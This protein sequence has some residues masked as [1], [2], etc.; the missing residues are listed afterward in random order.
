M[1]E[2][3]Q[4]PEEAPVETTDTVEQPVDVSYDDML[5]SDGKFNEAWRENLPDELG[6]HSIWQKYDNPIDLIKGSINAQSHIGKKAEEFWKSANIEDVAK[7]N[8]IMGVP[9]NPNEYVF[10]IKE[11]PD[12]LEVDQ[13]R[14]S[15]FK[16]LAYNLGLSQ[17]QAEKLMDWEIETSAKNLEDIERIDES[18]IIEAEQALRQE[19]QGDKYEYNMGKVANVMDY[20]GLGEFKDDPAIG[21]N[22]DFIKTVFE[23][24]VPLIDEDSLIQDGLEQNYAT[25]NDQLQEL[26]TKIYEFEGNTSEPAYQKMLRERQALLEKIS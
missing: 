13:N 16:N 22:V 20:L 10:E 2:D 19:W 26:E 9:Q 23:K 7:R 3:V 5:T 12:D 1:S 11:L 17:T 15:D 14:M 4:T 24:V 18:S 8:E 25:V 6:R 21:N